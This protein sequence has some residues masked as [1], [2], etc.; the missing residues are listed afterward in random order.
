MSKYTWL[1]IALFFQCYSNAQ[2][3]LQADSSIQFEE[4][5]I[6]YKAGN[7]TPVTFQNITAKEIDQ[8]SFGKEPSF[9]LAKTPS[10]T[11]YSDAG[12][13]NGYSYIRLRGIDQTRINMTLD[14]M[15]LN[16]PED[17]GVY[18]SNYPDLFNS[19]SKVQVQRGVGTS[20]NGAA[21]YA[22]N[23]QLFS[24]DLSDTTKTTIGIGY[25]SF[26]SFRIFAEHNSGI[27]NN[28]AIYARVSEVYSEG[29]KYNSSNHGQSAFVSGGLFYDK[30][31]W[32]VN[33][34]AGRQNNELAWI[35]VTDSM[36]AIDRR[37]N[38]NTNENDQF[39][40]ATIQLQN[41]WHISGHSQLQSSAYYTYL[42]G[43]YDFNLNNFL[44]YPSTAELYNYAFRSRLAG[45]FTNYTYTK[46]RFTITTGTHANVYTRRHTGSEKSLGTLYTNTG[47][48]NET[49]L[50]VKANYNTKW[51][52]FFT[53]V[54][55]RSTSFYYTGS[56][57]I[58][59][60]SWDFINPK[61][62]ISAPVDNNTVLYYSIG[63]TGREPTRNDIFGGNDDL[64]ADGLGN[65]E[66]FI[67]HPEYVTDQ[68]LGLRYNS[69]KMCAGFNLY[70]MRFNNEIVLN[71]N[72]GP[73]GLALTNNVDRSTRTGAELY[74][75]YRLSPAFKLV[76]NSSYN[77]SRIT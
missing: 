53:D 57:P 63:R 20:K 40:Q 76:N 17:Q 13:S 73:N 15:P 7:E 47:Q 46:K 3:A 68:E 1:F 65:P 77:Y 62:G 61:A 60:L 25:G 30:T 24:P 39:T 52:N 19:V 56:V 41:Q 6:S 51:L 4:V 16:E 5:I 37:S 21:G 11:N 67:T 71:G 23:I 9:L 31:T 44:G 70:H 69:S 49:S 35:G 14:G 26:N 22:G 64:L 50:F 54:Q 36:I 66:L 8:I 34:F 59:K 12:S 29:Y 10:I 74:I 27:K 75:T 43:G 32:K 48:K 33:V 28:K 18:F 72:F 45:V 55:Y 2:E 58:S 42:E 38:A